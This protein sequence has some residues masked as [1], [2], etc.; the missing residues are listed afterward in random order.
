MAA[1]KGTRMQSP[2]TAKVMFEVGGF[3]MVH[4][5]VERALECDPEMVIAI[6]GHNRESVR[7]YLRGAFGDRVAFAEQVE[8]LGTGH[9]IMQAAPLLS[10]FDGDVIVLSGDV[11]LLRHHTLAELIRVHREENAAATVLTVT[12][13]D[14]AGYGR[15]VRRDDGSVE[16]IVE[17]KDASDA[18]RAI[19]EI[20]SGIYLFR[21]PQLLEALS[22]LRND[23]AQGEYY[24]T[25]VFGWLRSQGARVAAWRSPDFGEIQGINTLG[26]LAEVNE[27][28]ARRTSDAPTADIRTSP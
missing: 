21:T 26:Q 1:G 9:A 4:H 19:D 14:P 10:D 28:F 23:N 7:A 11:P 24:L 5:V 25:D 17:H 12:A 13:P 6:I 22:H 18:E 2:E 27:E 20:N 3:P 8:Q 16:R 15:V